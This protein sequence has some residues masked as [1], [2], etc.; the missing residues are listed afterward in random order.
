MGRVDIA[1]PAFPSALAAGGGSLWVLAGG[2]LLRIDTALDRVISQIDVGVRLGSEL[3]CDLTVAGKV[4]WAVG[5]VSALRSKVFRID[6]RSGRV[7]GSTAVPA[8]ACVAATA[9]GAWVPLPESRL[10]L[11]LGRNGRALER[12]ADCCVL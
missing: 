4:V 3:T 7:L 11:R 2:H 12:F 9:H 5:S 8:A 6:V 10:V 1:V